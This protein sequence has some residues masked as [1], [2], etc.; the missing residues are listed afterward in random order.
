MG[1]VRRPSQVYTSRAVQWECFWYANP[2]CFLC[3]YDTFD[4]CVLAA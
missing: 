3:N 4:W 2:G 1:L